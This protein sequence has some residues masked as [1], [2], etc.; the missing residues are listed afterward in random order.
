MWC[1]HRESVCDV[2]KGGTYGA[3][4]LAFKVLGQRGAGSSEKEHGDLH[5]D[6]CLGVYGF[7][8]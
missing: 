1:G 7:E 2:W 3:V 4:R 6:V 8:E 5:G